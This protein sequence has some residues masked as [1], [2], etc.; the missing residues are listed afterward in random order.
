MP[1]PPVSP[2][3]PLTENPVFLRAP[4][5]LLAAGAFETSPEF[6]V[7]GYTFITLYF[8]YIQGA[9]ASDGAFTFRI[10]CSPFAI[11]QVIFENWYQSALYEAGNLA[12]GAD[13]LSLIQ[14]EE[15]EYAAIGATVETFVYGPIPIQGNIERM[16]ISVAE[17]G[18]TDEPGAAGL[19]AMLY[20]LG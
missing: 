13:V 12:A 4:V 18:E 5:A 7:A 2:S 16:R 6:S 11:D 15:I 9:G 14:R 17:S 20:S 19:I 8:Q 3:A 1:F 10:E